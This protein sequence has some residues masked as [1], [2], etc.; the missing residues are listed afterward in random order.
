M[1]YIISVA[2]ASLA[3][4]AATAE[5]PR[6][7]TDF[8]PAQGLVAMV[9]GDL[10]S[11][12]M[13]LEQGANAHDFQLR[14]SQAAALADADLVVW[15]G[16]EMSPWLERSLDGLDGG[17]DLRLLTVEGTH[18][19]PFGDN[20]AHDHADHDEHADHDDHGPEAVDDPEGHDHDHDGM[21]PH[22]WLDPSNGVHWLDAIAA[23]L[24]RLDPGNAAT[25]AANAA[26]GKTRITE[27]DAALAQRLAPLHDRPF[28]VF[29]DAY[30]Y[31]TAHYGLTVAGSVAAGDAASPGAAHLKELQA[32]AGSTALCLFPEAGHDPKLLAQMAEAT[33]VKLGGALDPE[34]VMVAPDAGAYLAVLNGVAD[35][36]VAC[37]TEG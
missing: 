26:A 32:A 2:I 17:A 27:A 12:E 24:G 11:P 7:V 35:T 18:L 34:G 20:A 33:G 37:L 22:A 31:F 23:E 14:P 36:L 16:P 28:V 10:G 29:H 30:G 21:D 1:R 5:V 25:Y 13:L 3:A 15:M 9:M 6:V 4:T 8:A 19:Q